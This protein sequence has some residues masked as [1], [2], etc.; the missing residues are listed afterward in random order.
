MDNMDK[1]KN[2]YPLTK[3]LEYILKSG[4]E[5]REWW[6]TSGNNNFIYTEVPNLN[7]KIAW[8]WAC[9]YVAQ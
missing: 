6:K 2:I 8:M 7:S 5:H 3:D 9:C 4:G 1:T